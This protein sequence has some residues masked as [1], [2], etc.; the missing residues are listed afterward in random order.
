M[1]VRRQYSIKRQVEVVF[2]E[3]FA[4]GNSGQVNTAGCEDEI[5]NND[6]ETVKEK[7]TVNEHL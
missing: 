6:R 5:N 2:R 7:G 3:V 4:V 1:T